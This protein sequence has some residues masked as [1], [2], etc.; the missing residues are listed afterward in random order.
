[1]SVSN[2]IPLVGIEKPLGFGLESSSEDMYEE[3]SSEEEKENAVVNDDAPVNDNA[4]VVYGFDDD[5]TG[6]SNFTLYSRRDIYLSKEWRDFVLEWRNCADFLVPEPPVPER[7]NL[8][9]RAI[10][11]V[12]WQRTIL[13][14]SGEIIIESLSAVI[15]VFSI[16]THRERW[17]F[18]RLFGVW[19]NAEFGPV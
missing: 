19:A 7:L 9:L 3:P 13:S 11:G 18:L 8:V 17:E 10:N 4:P 16:T 1:M 5:I 14:G 6:D 2:D 12:N 15:N